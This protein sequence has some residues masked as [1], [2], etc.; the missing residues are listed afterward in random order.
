MPHIRRLRAPQS[1]TPPCG[2]IS[3]N[4]DLSEPTGNTN[5]AQHV[6]ENLGD[7]RGGRALL[8]GVCS[9]LGGD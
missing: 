6:K 4:S 9:L 7:R 5:K 1:L 2:G 3:P 8:L